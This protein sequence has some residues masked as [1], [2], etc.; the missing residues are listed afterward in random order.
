[1]TDPL[2]IC[3]CVKVVPRAAVPLRLDPGTGRLDR[4]GAAEV[5]SFDTY[6]VE[7]ALR[8]RDQAGGGEVVI[9]SLGPEQGAESLRAVLAMGADRAVTVSDPA[10]EGSDL[11]GTS[12]VL[13]AAI[14]AE[15]PDIV[16]F[17]AQSVDGAGAI[18]WTAV[19]ERLSLPVVSGARTIEVDAGRLRAARQ[20]AGGDQVVE[21][22]LPCV[23]SISGSANT[24]R[25]P[26]FRDIVQAKK[27][28]IVTISLADLGVPPDQVG[29]A[30]AK[31]EVL[32]VAPAPPRRT[33][34]EVLEDGGQG[35][36]WLAEF[37]GSKGLL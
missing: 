24:P 3:V 37:L 28:T 5:N 31:T 36:A 10:V 19:A 33:S 7:E 32:S 11:L 35:A 30:G 6:A 15:R 26:S 13:A 12:R 17:G 22:P 18:L 27:K 14:A 8:L 20:V 25:Y 4:S 16:L 23:V 2:R 1:M 9:V 21:S 34:G 29:T